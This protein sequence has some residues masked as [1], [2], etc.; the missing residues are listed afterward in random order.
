MSGNNN[1]HN[2]DYVQL[3]GKLLSRTAVVM[4]L[5]FVIVLVL[6]FLFWRQRGG[7][8]IVDL[9]QYFAG[10]EEGE[11]I[12]F[13]W[14]Y[15][16][17]YAPI[18]WVLS[19]FVMFLVLMRA[20]LNHFI[21]Y[22]DRVNG[23]IAAILDERAEIKLPS[24]LSATERKLREV[25][26]ELKQRTFDVQLAEQRKNDLV[27][28]LAHDIRTP[29][30]SVIGYLNLLE[31]APDMPAEQKAKYIGITLEKAYRL[32]HMVDEFFEITKYN[33]RQISI[34]KEPID[35]YYMLVQLT[36]EFTP[37]LRQN[38]NTIELIAPEEL[39]V[40]GDP[41]KLARV[42]NNVLKNAVSYSF[43]D[44]PIRITAEKEGDCIYIVFTNQGPSLPAERLEDIFEKFYRMDVARGS[45]SGGSGLGLAIAR[46]I[47]TLHGGTISAQCEGNDI[48][49]H[50]SLP[51]AP[52]DS[53]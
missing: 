9:L 50:I 10:M 18:I 30:T 3:K 14:T 21:D 12:D 23:G 51:A 8:L 13:Y 37:M 44:S 24:E 53:L 22:F 43:A 36:D 16:R 29:L 28:Y 5:A 15:V 45:H 26:G 38:G 46:E 47:V 19:F 42:L 20:V 32:E 4:A 35:L 52:P 6:Y 17:S 1:E 49:F 48:S 7:N 33:L 27:M 25:Q 41:D 40:F 39:T 2:S 11:A 34:S 31:E